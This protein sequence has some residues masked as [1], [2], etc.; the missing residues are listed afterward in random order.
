[1]LYNFKELRLYVILNYNMQKISI[2]SNNRGKI[3]GACLL[4]FIVGF[5]A[6]ANTLLN[7]FI[8]DDEYL[9]LNNS[10]V[11]SFTHLPNVFKTYVKTSIIF[12]DPSRKYQI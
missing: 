11:K 10:Q 9:I 5:M 7:D 1:M 6:Y 3:I 2:N 8:W 12:T 4:V